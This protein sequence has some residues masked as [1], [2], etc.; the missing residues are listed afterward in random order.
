MGHGASLS[1]YDYAG[2]D[3]VNFCDPDGRLQTPE[4]IGTVLKLPDRNAVGYGTVLKPDP[5]DIRTIQAVALQPFGQRF[6]TRLVRAGT[7]G[8]ILSG[9]LPRMPGADAP[10][11]SSYAL[12]EGARTFWPASTAPG[13][14]PDPTGPRAKPY[15]GYPILIDPSKADVRTNEQITT[16]MEGR[17]SSRRIQTYS[18][19][20]VHT[21]EGEVAVVEASPRSMSTLP[22]QVLHNTGKA[23]MIVGAAQTAYNLEHATEISIATG[24]YNILANQTIREATGWAFAAAGTEIGATVGALGGP[25]APVTVPAGGLIGGGIGGA[26]GFGMDVRGRDPLPSDNPQP[27]PYDVKAPLIYD[28]GTGLTHGSGYKGRIWGNPIQR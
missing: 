28:S 18:E 27:H 2:G 21:G 24:D 1:L 20:Q 19:G 12:N 10:G 5:A 3:P 23:L 6:V 7:Q 14:A 11:W 16:D 25:F 15:N 22:G 13:G 17:Q 4:G 26:I 9:G 8:T